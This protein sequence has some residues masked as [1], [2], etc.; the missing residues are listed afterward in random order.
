MRAFTVPAVLTCLLA[1]AARAGTPAD[2]L[3]ALKDGTEKSGGRLVPE[4]E[5]ALLAPFSTAT[6]EECREAI[7]ALITLISDPKAYVMTIPNAAADRVKAV[8]LLEDKWGIKPA[9]PKKE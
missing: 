9:E 8:A 6:T 1:V 4:R 5:A 3:K 7:P 2:W